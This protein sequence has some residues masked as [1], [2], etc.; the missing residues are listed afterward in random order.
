MYIMESLSLEGKMNALLE[1]L[2]DEFRDAVVDKDEKAMRHF[3]TIV[4][5]SF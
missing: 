1:I 4:V 5:D 2:E 3:V